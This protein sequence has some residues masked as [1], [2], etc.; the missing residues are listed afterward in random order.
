MS[1]LIDAID[2]VVNAI[3]DFLETVLIALGI[4]MDVFLN[5]ILFPSFA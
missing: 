1:R 5:D 4:T 3:I 2:I